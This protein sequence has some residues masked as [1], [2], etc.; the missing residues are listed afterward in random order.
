MEVFFNDFSDE[1]I[2]MIDNETLD[3]IC[4]NAEEHLR[5]YKR[6]MFNN[7]RKQL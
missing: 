4:N 7:E 1:K 6:S 2:H 5:E 3:T